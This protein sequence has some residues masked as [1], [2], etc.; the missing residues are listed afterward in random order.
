MLLLIIFVNEL[1][2][3]NSSTLNEKKS[4]IFKGFLKNLT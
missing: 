1:S 3:M 4:K 2:F